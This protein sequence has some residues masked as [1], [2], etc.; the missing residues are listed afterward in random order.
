MDTRRIVG[1]HIKLAR[2]ERELSQA[3]LA[4]MIGVEQA[5][6]SKIEKGTIDIGISKLADFARVLGK[7]TGWFFEEFREDQLP[8]VDSP[9][10]GAKK[11][12]AA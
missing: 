9:G 5:Y 10:A 6:V 3:Q 2:V 12:K 8:F 11:K 1:K 4:E 7:P